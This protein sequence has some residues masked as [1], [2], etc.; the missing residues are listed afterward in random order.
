M[1]DLAADYGCLFK[2]ESLTRLVFYRE[3]ELEVAESVAV[4]NVEDFEDF[5]NYNLRSTSVGT[6]KQ[7]QVGYQRPE[8]D[9][10]EVTVGLDGK[11]SS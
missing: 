3:I 8:Q 7:A 6:Y 5:S 11:E 9:F 4:F 2:I 1:R 10:I